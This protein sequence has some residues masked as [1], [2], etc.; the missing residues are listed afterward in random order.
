MVIVRLMNEE[1]SAQDYIEITDIIEQRHGYDFSRYAPASLKRRILRFME[2]RHINSFYDLKYKLINEA[3]FFH[4]MLQYITVNVTE[5]FRDPQF[6]KFMREQI[7]PVLA[8][9]P[10]IKIWHAGCSTGEEVFSMCILLHEAGLLERSVIYATDLNPSNLEK[11]ESG[12][13]PLKYMKEYTQNYIQSGGT[14]EF[15]NYY[16]AHYE[17]ILINKELRKNISFFQHSLVSDQAF[18]EFHLVVCRNV[19][20]YFNRDLQKRVLE[21]FNESLAPLGFLALGIKES[22]MVSGAQPH[23]ETINPYLKIYRKKN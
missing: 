22:L 14:A 13:V 18:H 3:D 23:F 1:I 12:I 2:S 17:N 10:I 21:L 11:A 4:Q 8:S 15:S 9:Y 7:I 16:T 6:Y 20:I 19:L 5:M